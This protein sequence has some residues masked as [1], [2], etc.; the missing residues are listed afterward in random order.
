MPLC[1]C[2][3]VWLCSADDCP[4]PSQ[5]ESGWSTRPTVPWQPLN[6]FLFRTQESSGFIFPHPLPP[7]Q[8]RRQNNGCLE[9]RPCLLSAYPSPARGQQWGSAPTV[10]GPETC[11]VSWES[12]TTLLSR[13]Y[14]NEGA[15]GFQKAWERP[16][17]FSPGS[18]R[19]TP[20]P[21]RCW[22]CKLR[23]VMCWVRPSGSQHHLPLKMRI[24]LM[25]ARVVVTLYSKSPS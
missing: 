11:S 24:L 12:W 1:W 25:A 8:P 18:F 22:G 7:I 19:N 4:K 10:E 5:P 6:D 14:Q 23:G 16:P 15:R 20:A 13:R 21:G 2:S 3:P 17:K 9:A